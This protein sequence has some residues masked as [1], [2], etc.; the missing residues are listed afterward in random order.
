VPRGSHIFSDL[1]KHSMA[2]VLYTMVVLLR[3][4]DDRGKPIW[5]YLCMKPSMAE[6][7]SAAR[8]KGDLDLNDF[9]TILESGS[10]HEVPEDVKK[11]MERD[12]GVNHK[13]EDALASA[14]AA[15]K[16]IQ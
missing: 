3:A 7:L 14:V 13:L 12:F 4:Y 16:K 5:A 9:G 10:G 8:L 15:R 6:E 2:D 1:A 11:R